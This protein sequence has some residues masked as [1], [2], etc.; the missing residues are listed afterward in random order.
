MV[1][2]VIYRWYKGRGSQSVCTSDRDGQKID[3]HDDGS[4][5]VGIEVEQHRRGDG[6]VG[7]F[8]D[9]DERPDQHQRRQILRETCERGGQRPKYDGT[10][11]E[12]TPV[13][14]FFVIQ[15]PKHGSE[16]HIH[17]HLHCDDRGEWENVVIGCDF[18]GGRVGS[19]AGL[20]HTMPVE[21]R[22]DSKSFRFKSAWIN[23]FTELGT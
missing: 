1:T 16:E 4:L 2:G 20:L 17:Q 12:V 6:G 10:P 11:D 9:P 5:L 18:L 13:H 19:C 22:L 23:D 8:P 15:H 3:A 7:C 21:G 14:E